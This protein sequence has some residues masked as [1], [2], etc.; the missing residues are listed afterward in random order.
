MKRLDL[1]LFLFCTICLWIS[2]CKDL[3]EP[4]INKRQVTVEAPSDGFKTPLY[5]VSFWWDEVEDALKYRLQITSPGFSQPDRLVL[6]T[7]V[8]GN[9]FSANVDPGKYQWRLRAENGSSATDYSTPRSFEVLQSSIKGQSVELIQ[10]ANGL[11]TN[12]SRINLSW[13][14]LYGATQYRVQIDTNNFVSESSLV[15]NQSFPGTTITF[16]PAR[17]QVY[18]W[19]V[20]A[21]NDTA[22]ARW[23]AV[24]QFTVDRIP[25]QRVKALSPADNASITKPVT[26]QWENAS[27]AIRYRL[28]VM[29]ADSVTNYNDTFPVTT[30]DNNYNFQSGNSNERIYWKVAAIDAAGNIGVPSAARSF[31]IR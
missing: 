24:N 21:E 26:L 5:K 9:K 30:T 13:G 22:Q 29:K 1:T 15:F 11:L 16:T 28:Y 2:G 8:T 20:R 19:R 10:P 4:S 27:G 23:S 12:N 31:I 14:T 7:L 17:D 3:I 18:Q 6:D 25:P